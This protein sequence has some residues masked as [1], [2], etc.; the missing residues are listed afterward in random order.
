M[1]IDTS[2]L[3]SYRD[4]M[5]EEADAFIAEIISSFLEDGPILVSTMED[6]IATDNPETF[7]RAAHTLKSNSATVGATMLTSLAA[8]M[9]REG[10]FGN[11]AGL[12]E[13]VAQSKEELS[14]VTDELKRM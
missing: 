13:K 10:K 5:G 3:N 1:N 11:I 6:A 2:T 12:H 14:C 9:E 7:V 8:E 4:F